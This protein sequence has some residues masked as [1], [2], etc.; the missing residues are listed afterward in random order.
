M[1]KCE[2]KPRTLRA[3]GL[4]NETL[5]ARPKRLRNTSSPAR[6]ARIGKT[7][8]EIVCGGFF[9]CGGTV[10]FPNL[11]EKTPLFFGTKVAAQ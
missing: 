10:S 11:F 6:Y 5:R 1:D 9:P 7:R 4:P 3:S 2:A 8:K